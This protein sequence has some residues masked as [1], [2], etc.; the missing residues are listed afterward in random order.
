MNP[1]HLGSDFR[2]EGIGK[3]VE[4]PFKRIMESKLQIRC[5]KGLCFQCEE[6]NFSGTS[7]KKNELQVMVIHDSE[8]GEGES[9]EEVAM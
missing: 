7:L 5:E 6:K 1:S 8:H 3:H 2:K 9:C 4:V